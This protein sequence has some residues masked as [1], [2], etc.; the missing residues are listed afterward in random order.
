MRKTPIKNVV[1]AMVNDERV[2]YVGLSMRSNLIYRDLFLSKY[3][4]VAANDLCQL[5]LLPEELVFEREEWLMSIEE[6]K[7]LQRNVPWE[8]ILQ[9]SQTYLKSL[10]YSSHVD[11]LQNRSRS[12][13]NENSISLQQI[14]CS[15]TPTVFWY[16]NVHICRTDHYRDFVFSWKHKMVKSGG[17]VEDKLSPALVRALEKHGLM[18]GHAKFGCYLLDDHS[19]FFFT[20]HMDGGNFIA[21]KD[22]SYRN[23]TN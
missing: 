5:V 7:N 16:D 14:Q 12:F 23:G 1:E 9:L 18:Q 22:L 10:Q 13:I 17:F 21:G 15:L 6:M 3:G 8:N 20:G 2:K 11:M 19:G 4:K